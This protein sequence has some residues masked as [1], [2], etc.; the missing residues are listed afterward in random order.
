[1]GSLRD[2]HQHD[3][4]DADSAH[5]ERYDGNRR[6]HQLHRGGGLVDGLHDAVAAV[7]VEI[8]AAVA[9]REQFRDALFGNLIGDSVF[10][11]HGDG[12]E[13]LLPQQSVHGGAVRYPDLKVRTAGHGAVL[14]LGDA[15]NPAGELADE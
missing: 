7:R 1:M 4:H 2:R 15:D 8:L 11:P 3:V 14:L 6:D 5:D 13:M 12:I 10:D 9:L